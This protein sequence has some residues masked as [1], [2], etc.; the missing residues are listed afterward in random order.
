MTR[1]EEC[2]LE[3]LKVGVVESNQIQCEATLNLL[4]IEGCNLSLNVSEWS[5]R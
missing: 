4:L 2:Q 1:I 5:L 3:G